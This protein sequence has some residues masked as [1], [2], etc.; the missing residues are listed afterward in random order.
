MEKRPDV[1][2]R[3]AARSTR[4]GIRRWLK[5][6]GAVCLLGAASLYCHQQI[7]KV[8]TLENQPHTDSPLTLTWRESPF[9][10][11]PL[12][13]D[14]FKFIPCTN[15]SL[16]PALDDPHPEDT[17]AKLFDAEPS[18]WSWGNRSDSSQHV[19]SYYGRGI[20]LCGYL[21]VPLDYTNKSDPR[22]VRLAV[23]KFQVSGL[24]RVGDPLNTNRNPP[25]G[26]KSKRTIVIEPGG[27]GG[28]GTRYTWQVAE[29]VSKR[30]SDGAFDVLGWD[31]RGVNITR[32]S[33]A[34]FPYDVDR[35]HWSLL[36]G[37]YLQVSDPKRQINLADAMNEATMKA[38]WETHGDIGRFLSTTFVARDLEEIRKAI[39][40]EELTG[41]LVS[42]GTGIGQTYANIFPQSVGRMILDGTEYV[43]DHRLLGGFGWTALDNATNAWHDGFLGECINAGPNHCALARSKHGEPVA[44]EELETRMISLIDSLIERPIVGYTKKNGPSLVTYSALVAAIYSSLYNAESWPALARMLYELEAGNSTLATSFLEK[45]TWEYDPSLPATPNKRPSSDELTTLVICSDSWDAPLPPDGLVWWESLWANMTTKS[46]VSGDARFSD[47]FPC[48]HFTKYWPEPAG[49]YRG[50]LNHTLKNPVLLI[51]ETYDPATPLRNG[52]RLLNEMG[53]NARLIAHHGYGHS[54]RDTSNCTESIAKKYILRGELPNEQETAC[55]ANEKPYLYGVKDKSVKTAEDDEWDPV[56]VWLEA[57]R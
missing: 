50:D 56:E 35:D 15:T 46:W 52:R 43:R 40:E 51:A 28:S 38:C 17:W 39:G 19:D 8:W 14:P 36:T 32:P 20:Y 37:Q 44:L 31:P 53:Q 1:D 48:Q 25:P 7:I 24:A 54:S 21:D 55:Y 13:Q 6:G 11:F 9:G 45:S 16:P 10:R 47:V 3:P 33:I 5:A 41:Y 27:P 22:I 12:P 26:G 42:Y 4:P 18:H 49:V 29:K 30:F 57:L 2:V 34:C 23:T